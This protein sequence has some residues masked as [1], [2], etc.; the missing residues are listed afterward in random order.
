MKRSRPDWND[1]RRFGGPHDAYGIYGGPGF[2]EHFGPSYGGPYPG[3]PM[4]H[5]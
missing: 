4:N 5:R 1:D 3:G 2:G